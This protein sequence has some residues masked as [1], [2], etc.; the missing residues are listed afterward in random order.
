MNVS[1]CASVEH[2]V[3]EN[4]GPH[5]D[6][7]SCYAACTK[8]RDSSQP[9][10][11]FEGTFIALQ[12]VLTEDAG[13]TS[14]TCSCVAGVK[15]SFRRLAPP[16]FKR[17]YP[18]AAVQPPAGGLG[19]ICG[20]CAD[21]QLKGKL[22][23][24]NSQSVYIY[25]NGQNINDTVSEGLQRDGE[26]ANVQPSPS[27]PSSNTL[28]ILTLLLPLAAVFV[29][30][31]IRL[32]NTKK[33]AQPTLEKH[34]KDYKSDSSNK[35]KDLSAAPRYIP[36]SYEPAVK[37]VV[38]TITQPPLSD[39][40][41][42]EAPTTFSRTISCHSAIGYDDATTY[43]DDDDVHSILDLDHLQPLSV[44][45]DTM[46]PT[47]LSETDVH[48]QTL[49][50]TFSI[51]STQT[52][53]KDE[54]QPLVV[55]DSFDKL[56]PPPSS[57]TTRMDVDTYQSSTPLHPPHLLQTWN[58][59]TAPTHIYTLLQ[60]PVLHQLHP[61]PSPFTQG[62]EQEGFMQSLAGDDAEWFEKRGVGS[63]GE[64]LKAGSVRSL[65]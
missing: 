8:M 7:N 11:I 65:E 28:F 53:H 19:P 29:A 63:G 43:D 10:P 61:S 16:A 31:F 25:A 20:N 34:S 35:F 27:T 62:G 12:L 22:C 33:R 58:H 48:A 30:C 39:K 49:S 36:P 23:G 41:A 38:E 4:L 40:L 17:T 46:T 24:L 3:L 57:E 18:S 5:L 59:P 56:S 50:P 51:T 13:S 60:A 32:Q 45:C 52:D 47:S 21:D 64:S 2:L 15:D 44:R 9:P 14:S 1:G 55:V 6:F 26:I 37:V 54:T 42:P